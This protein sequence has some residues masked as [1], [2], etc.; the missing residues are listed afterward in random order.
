MEYLTDILGYSALIVTMVGFSLRD[1]VKLQKLNLAGCILWAGHFAL[2]QEIAAFIMLVLAT[3]IVGSAIFNMKRATNAA[4]LA[5]ILMIPIF[6]AVT[7]SNGGSWAGIL[8]IL[9]GFFINTGVSRCT[10]SGM[11]LVIGL[12]QILWIAASFL[13]GSTPALIANTLN[14]CALIIREISRGRGAKQDEA[15]TA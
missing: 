3:I 11:T 8:P 4:W 2:M 7:L 12:G 9:G 5:N 10:G 14:F 13:M 6:S 15:T 1:D